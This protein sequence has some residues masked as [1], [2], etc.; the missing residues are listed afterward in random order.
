[1]AEQARPRRNDPAIRE[2]VV[3]ALA[4]EVAEWSGGD[5]SA[6]EAA[7]V[8]RQV[9]LTGNGYEIAKELDDRHHWE[10]IDLE[11]I[12]ILDGASCH[13]WR[14][15][16]E[17]MKAWVAEV[18]FVP[19]FKEGDRVTTPRGTGP[20]WRVEH[21]KAQY[22]VSIDGENYGLGGGAIVNAEDVTAEQVQS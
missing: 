17:A 8:L 7:A 18:G 13:M 10:G 15:H 16:D 22:V 6:V 3:L 20:V 11:L 2:A 12:E 14:A 4:A 1:M 21:D 19:A 9:W 5:L